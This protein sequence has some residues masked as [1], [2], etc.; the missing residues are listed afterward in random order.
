MIFPVRP[1][2]STARKNAIEA[3]SNGD[4]YIYGVG[5][6]DGQNDADAD[7]LPIGEAIPS[8]VVTSA[9]PSTLASDTI[10]F[11]Y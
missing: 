9:L 3:K 1:P 6:F 11:I 2:W 5:G 10:Y 7:V 4:V 8:I